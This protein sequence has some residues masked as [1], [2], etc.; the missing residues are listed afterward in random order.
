MAVQDVTLN[1][2]ILESAKKEFLSKGFLKASVKT[3]CENA[4]VTTGALYKR[5]KGKTDLFDAVVE[6]M[7]KKMENFGEKRFKR[8]SQYV[9]KRKTSAMWDQPEVSQLQLTNFLY[10]NYSELR[11]L[12]VCAEGTRHSHF[13]R[14]Y[15]SEVTDI[16]Y[17]FSVKVYEEGLSSKHV[18][19]ELIQTMLMAYYTS[20]FYPLIQGYSREKAIEHS[21]ALARF[22]N[23]QQVLGY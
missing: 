19:R 1:P 21:K 11:I 8:S 17:D 2:K 5:Y 13:L 7:Y 3:I 10:D 9:E 14:D 16:V 23:W 12:L 4:G 22:F 15:V 20:V 18:E 6:P